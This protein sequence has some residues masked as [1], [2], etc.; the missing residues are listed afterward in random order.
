MA[1]SLDTAR[2]VVLIA[3]FLAEESGIDLDRIDADDKL[4][5]LSVATE[6]LKTREWHDEL[7][8]FHGQPG[9]TDE[10]RV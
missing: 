6:V 9:Y 10:G 5:L 3:K 1:S 7:E 2:E 8:D 4:F